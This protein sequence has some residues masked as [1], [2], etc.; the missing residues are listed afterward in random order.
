MNAGSQ[1]PKQVP[2]VNEDID[3]RTLP[4]S[5]QEA[6]L[7]SCIDGVVGVEE[8]AAATAVHVSSTRAV[9]A[10]LERLGAIRWVP[11]PLPISKRPSKFVTAKPIAAP[12]QPEETDL[13]DERQRLILQM[14][15]RLDQ[16]THYSLL[17]V[18][19]DADRIAVR[20]AFFKHSKV[21]HPDS[22]Y[23]KRLGSYKA[24]MEKIFSRLSQAYE[25][26]SKPATRAEYDQYLKARA[27]TTATRELFDADLDAD[28]K[29]VASDGLESTP[30]SVKS[31]TSAAPGAG[32]KYRQAAA[33]RM[34]RSIGRSAPPSASS[35]PSSGARKEQARQLAKQV[36]GSTTAASSVRS[37]VG[38]ATHLLKAAQD[39]EQRNDLPA[40]MNAMR[41]ARAMAPSNPDIAAEYKRLRAL[42]SD[43]LVGD[44]IMQAKYE[45]RFRMWDAAADSW[46]K[47]AD[48]KPHD[49]QAHRRV[50]MVLLEGKGDMRRAQKFAKRAVEIKPDDLSCRVTLG[51]VFAEM[52]LKRNAQR[53][54]EEAL[55]ITPNDETVKEL[56]KK[57]KQ[58]PSSE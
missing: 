31:S 23:G 47:V 49:A 32:D 3:I 14:F 35:A 30:P 10:R 38:K 8:L 46:A 42:V 55:R 7:L 25:I 33:K 37:G 40:A 48:A 45:E 51:Q 6:Y 5:A 41:L 24:K 19:Q 15:A 17:G 43:K 21:F 26:L 57:L 52:G 13:D 56:I 11:A 39:A 44:Y 1:P 22:L 12:V 36:V 20:D 50:A 34:M 2:K 29:Q 9:L 58:E 27:H 54:F 16:G 53:E 28:S 18:K 4:L